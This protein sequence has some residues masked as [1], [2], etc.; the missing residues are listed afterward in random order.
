MTILHIDANAE[1]DG[2]IVDADT[3]FTQELGAECITLLMGRITSL[4]DFDPGAF[5]RSMMQAMAK[6]ASS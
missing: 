3:E 2:I 5:Q 1:G 4:E 6:L